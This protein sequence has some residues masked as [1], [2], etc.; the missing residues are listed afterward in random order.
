MG[1]LEDE[2]E[3]EEMVGND[4]PSIINIVRERVE[5]YGFLVYV[6][7]VQLEKTLQQQAKANSSSGGG[8]NRKKSTGLIAALTMIGIAL[9]AMS[10]ILII[11]SKP[12]I[13][14][15]PMLMNRLFSTSTQRGAFVGMFL[16]PCYLLMEN[17]V[18]LKDVKGLRQQQIFRVLVLAVVHFDQVSNVQ[19]SLDQLFLYFEHLAEPLAEFLNMLYRD[20]DHTILTEEMIKEMSTRDFNSNDNKGPKSVGALLIK[21]AQ[22]APK[23]LLKYFSF[24]ARMLDNESS[25]IRNAVVESTGLILIDIC[26]GI[27]TPNATTLGRA[28]SEADDIERH[29]PTIRSLFDLLEERVLDINP[30][31]R[32]RAIQALTNITE[33]NSKFN[34]RR[35]RMTELAVQALQ[36]KSHFVRKNSLRLLSRLISTHPFHFFNEG[37]RLNLSEWE[38]KFKSV[39]AELDSILPSDLIERRA[40]QESPND[41]DLDENIVERPIEAISNGEDSQN[42]ESNQTEP[43]LEQGTQEQTQSN[44]DSETI[45]KLRL[46]FKYHKDAITFIQ[47]VHEGLAYA[48]KLLHSK[49]KTEVIESMDLFVLA[50]AY[51]IETARDG[52]RS[53]IHLVWAKGGGNNDEALAI[54][55]H[56]LSCYQSLF[57]VTPSEATPGETNNMIARSL[58]SL[59]YGATVSEITSLERLLGFAMS[60]SALSSTSSSSSNKQQQTQQ[61]PDNDFVSDRVL[62]T[63]R[64]ISDGVV[65][66]LWKLY[67]YNQPIAKS[68]RR[69]AIIILGMLAKAD[70]KIVDVAGLELL[71]RIGLGEHGRE[72]FKLARYTCI[73]LQR[74]ITDENDKQKL[75][76]MT[77]GNIQDEEPIQRK[78]AASHEVIKKLASFIL[79]PSKS[80]EWL[81][82]CEEAVNAIYAICDTPDAVMSILLRLKSKQVFNP[83]L[84]TIVDE[85]RKLELKHPECLEGI[86]N[87]SL[88]AQL[89]F[90][91]GHTAIKTLVYLERIETQFKRRK[92]E[93]DRE[94]A[95]ANEREKQTEDEPTNQRGKG[96]RK[97]KQKAQQDEEMTQDQELNLI[98]GGTTEDDFSEE[99]T[100]IREHEL[101]F[102]ERSLLPIFGQIARSLCLD[103]IKDFQTYKK[104]EA[105]RL[106]LLS[107]L[108]ERE[109]T[110]RRKS[111]MRKSNVSFR[112]EPEL[113]PLNIDQN[114]TE[115]TPVKKHSRMLVVASTLAL[116]KMMCVSSKFCEEN[117]NVLL[118]LLEVTGELDVPVKPD[119]PVEEQVNDGDES[120]DTH[121][122]AK[123]NRDSSIVQNADSEKEFKWVEYSKALQYY[124]DLLERYETTAIVRSNIILGLGDLAVQFNH[125]MED[126]T[127]YVYRRLRDSSR[128]VQRTTL[129]T[130]TFLILAGQVKAKDQQLLGQMARCLADP[131]ERIA[132]LARIFF[133]ELSTKDN[134][135]YNNFI[136]MF[137][138]LISYTTPGEEVPTAVTRD[139]DNDIEMKDNDYVDPTETDS[140]RRSLESVTSEFSLSKDSVHR[141][142]RFLVG[143]VDKERYIKQLSDKLAARL[144]KCD[145]QEM[146][147]YTA[148][149]LGLLPHKNE[150]ITKLVQN[151]FQKVETVQQQ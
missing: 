37:G 10:Q 16:K 121:V 129:L 1:L 127:E 51:N 126:N 149:V 112:E 67:G 139:A 131:D 48:Q 76:T 78:F 42:K 146:W 46:A 92:M 77:S 145:T 45:G 53:M 8:A 49:N 52:V 4:T 132:N 151:G 71:L 86:D 56:L 41:G 91:A 134:A 31:T 13:P 9:E 96:R 69:G 12:L 136:D 105:K 95:E 113:D 133:L 43:E 50:D 68:Q 110:E 109:R 20:Y 144:F 59:T 120:E 6:L 70:S 89:L 26:K 123:R 38:T 29:A 106:Q 79:L 135:I 107:L 62:P 94:R 97:R 81:A 73:A 24:I 72:D 104:Q 98:G 87:N 138:S 5:R 22:L 90:L 2:D 11:L 83:K 117:L 140:L 74:M 63:T 47:K 28:N 65:Q 75:G 17:E 150:E 39:E 55:K 27:S 58:I 33:L 14:Q 116:A 141:I 88:L 125:V 19:T 142:L 85:F 32:S 115:P 66:V 102:G 137:N 122:S 3:D 21:L 119:E 36:D 99:L 111:R 25:T 61:D 130:L 143:L 147:D 30:Y 35:Y 15:Q 118:T 57:F 18:V 80:M 124:H 101:M 82:V 93:L 7:A 128:M 103:T 100:F 34:Q 148:Y 114:I 54:Q 44:Y 64:M 40:T 23:L 60:P 84:P 108:K